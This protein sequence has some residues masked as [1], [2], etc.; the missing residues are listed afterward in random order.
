MD[1]KKAARE[2][3]YYDKIQTIYNK[4]DRSFF[5]KSYRFRRKLNYK[6]FLNTS[7]YT[8]YYYPLEI[9]T[10]NFFTKIDNTALKNLIYYSNDFSVEQTEQ[11]YNNF[12]NLKFFH[13][14][15]YK[16]LVLSQ[17]NSNFPTSYTHV[18][19]SFNS[20]V[21]EG[22]WDVLIGGNIKNSTEGY[23]LP[24]K[25]TN[26]VNPFKLRKTTKNSIVAYN[27]IQ[28]VYKS[29]FDDGRANL[30]FNNFFNSYQTQ[31]YLTESKINYEKILGKNKESFFN[32]DSYNN[33]FKNLNSE[34]TT[35]YNLNNSVFINIPFLLSMKSDAS[36]YL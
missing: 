31:S 20:T 32:I 36:R 34:F 29:R 30:N 4:G 26:K 9:T 19:D 35:A 25:K 13:H 3:T 7:I 33:L 12:K 8:S 22:D 15:F 24:E 27:S 28:K 11:G 5:D 2:S 14:F 21:D 6:S 18:F 17:Y 1:S 16:S 10:L 23:L